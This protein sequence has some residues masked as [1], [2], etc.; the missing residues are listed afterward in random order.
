MGV[1]RIMV[2]KYLRHVLKER[3]QPGIRSPLARSTDRFGVLHCGSL[4]SVMF[5]SGGVREMAFTTDC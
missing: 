1:A 5:T 2:V 3:L 4:A